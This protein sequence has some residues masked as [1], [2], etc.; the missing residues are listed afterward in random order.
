MFSELTNKKKFYGV[1]LLFIVLSIA[2][3]KRSFKGAIEAV[4]YYSESKKN[5]EKN[6]NIDEDLLQ[7]KNEIQSLDNI[8]G[9]KAKNPDIVQNEIL[10]FISQQEHNFKLSKIEN[11]HISSD[12]YFTI[13]SNMITLEGS[14]N[15]LLKAIYRFEKDFEYA[16]IASIKLHVLKKQQNS[17]NKLFTKIIFQNYE[18]N[19]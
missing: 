12:N 18:K 16:R 5:I 2:A 3:Y 9:K 13:Y 8:I 15:E 6:I 4:N 19:H 11:L 14:F 17:K 10:N 1:L 7:L